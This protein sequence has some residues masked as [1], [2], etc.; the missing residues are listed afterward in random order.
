MT[1]PNPII[2]P[3]VGRVVWFYPASNTAESGFVRN[4][5]GGPYAAIIAR[6]W[7]DRMLNLSVFDA[8]GTPHSRTSVTMVQGD[9]PA[10]DSAFC[11]WMPFQRG[12]AAK[13]DAQVKEANGGPCIR[14]HRDDLEHSAAHALATRVAELGHNGARIGTEVRLALD[15]LLSYGARAAEP[16][17]ETHA[18]RVLYPA[19]RNAM[20]EL[21]A[22]HPGFNDRV[23][24]AWNY[25]HGA[26]WSE[27]PA[28]ASAPGL[29]VTLATNEALV[30][31]PVRDDHREEPAMAV[32]ADA[33]LAAAGYRPHFDFGDA[34]RH[35]K[36]GRRVTR[37]GW[38]GTGMWLSLSG[39][40]TGREIAFENFW[41]KNNSE[42][43]RLNGGSAVVL[44]SISMKTVDGGIL[45]GW[46]ASQTDMLAEDWVV[47]D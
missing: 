38:N 17:G 8:N 36:A 3:T 10:P 21:A 4:E 20:E 27:T 6:V 45:M 19:I 33:A 13:Q 16:A 12:Q 14:S 46:L 7:N 24:C 22:L 18:S 44:P 9:D 30:G 11:G 41:S 47:V 42:F 43:A 37:A 32:A 34:I 26:F 28:P 23:N 2:I 5:S 29:R 25:L 31:L 15:A 1:D 40:L 35:L 39:P